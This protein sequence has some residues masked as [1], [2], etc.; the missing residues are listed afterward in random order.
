M[1]G[2]PKDLIQ[3]HS[4]QGQCFYCWLAVEEQAEAALWPEICSKSSPVL[5]LLQLDQ[6]SLLQG[7]KNKSLEKQNQIKHGI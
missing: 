6:A 7:Y 1:Q 5:L 4:G 3:S 2:F